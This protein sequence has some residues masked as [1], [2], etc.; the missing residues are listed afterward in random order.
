[1]QQRPKKSHYQSKVF[2]FVSSNCADVV[3]RLLMMEDF[4]LFSSFDGN[5]M[6]AWDG[7]KS[8][9]RGKIDGWN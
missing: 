2:V 5:L 6:D 9:G 3:H 7:V 4:L 8:D 1:M